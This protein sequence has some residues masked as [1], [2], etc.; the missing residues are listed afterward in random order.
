RAIRAAMEIREAAHHLKLEVTAGINTGEVYVGTVGS[1]RYQETTVM[2][3]AVGLAARLQEQAQPGQILVGEVTQRLARRAFECT[4]CSL[5]L[6]GLARPTAGYVV[7]QA[8]SR[9][10][11]AR[12][13]EGLRAEMI[14][15]EEELAKLQAALT[16]V[17]QG[18]GQVVT[19]IGEAG[20]GKSRL[21]T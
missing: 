11:K 19:L 13:I 5:G 2:G 3:P 14:G 20:L 4:A 18:Q 12:G 10:E 7:E 1:E 17:L 16:Q 6:K 8:L 9:P 15:R 21:V